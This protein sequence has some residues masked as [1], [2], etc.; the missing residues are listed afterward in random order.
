VNQTPPQQRPIEPASP[1]TVSSEPTSH[2]HRRVGSPH[3]TRARLTAGIVFLLL[4]GIACVFAIPLLWTV[5]AALK[6]SQEFAHEPERLWPRHVVFENFGKAWTALPFAIFVRNTVVISVLA[7]FGQVV[8]S[9]LVA[10]GFARF[11]FIGRD[12]LF[13]LLL[14][15]MMLPGQVT[16][17]PVFLIW[18]DLHAIG[19][20]IP[21]ILPSFFA[22]AFSV[23]LLRQFFLGIPREL[24][25]AAALDGAGHLLVWWK[26]L[27]PVSGAA[28]ATVGV[29]AFFANWDSFEGPLIYLNDPQTYTVSV[30]LR[31]FQDTNGT[32]FE[33]IMAA[34]LIHIVP[35]IVIF[36]CAQRYFLKGI[37]ISGLGGR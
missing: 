3:E 5:S 37:A 11:K 6:S 7:T 36:F 23:F 34:S 20:F 15:T 16:M 31:M 33:Q 8:S 10:F 32:A 17:I 9:S 29:F 19:T 4:I 28:L 14:A 1:V 13:G 21:L 30:G 2:I 18:R 35:T 22:S 24:D 26:I 27:M 25:E 12:A